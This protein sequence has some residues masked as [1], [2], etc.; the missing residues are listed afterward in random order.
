MCGHIADI[1]PSIRHAEHKLLCG[2]GAN[3]LTLK[4]AERS[5]AVPDIAERLWMISVVLL[6]L[7]QDRGNARQFVINVKCSTSPA[8]TANYLRQLLTGQATGPGTCVMLHIAA[9]ECVPFEKAPLRTQRVAVMTNEKLLR[10][11][12]DAEGRHASAS[13]PVVTF[14]F[15]TDD[16]A[17]TDGALSVA[18]ALPEWLF[19]YLASNPRLTIHSSLL[20]YLETDVNPT[21]LKE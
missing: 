14:Y 20:G 17:G 13:T 3:S 15:T 9:V 19:K 1:V 11:G 6:D 5:L 21:I 8:D 18:F 7:L 2:G 10:E 16:G 12:Q 4:L